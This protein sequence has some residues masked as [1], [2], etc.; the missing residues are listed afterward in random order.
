VYVPQL[1]VGRRNVTRRRLQTYSCRQGDSLREKAVKAG[2]GHG[3]VEARKE[4]RMTQTDVNLRRES[5]V[6][7][8]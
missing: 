7:M 1:S 2:D 6:T 3:G 5:G 4:V 8:A